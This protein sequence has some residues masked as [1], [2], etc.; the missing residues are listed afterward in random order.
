V[1]EETS[2]DGRQAR[3]LAKIEREIIHYKQEAARLRANRDRFRE[4][5]ESSSDLLWE[6][7]KN[8]VFTYVSPKIRDIL[9]YAPEAVLGGTPFDLMPPKEAQRMSEIFL[10]KKEKCLPIVAIESINLHKDGRR[11]RF[12]T[13]GEPFFN[14]DGNL[15]GYRGV[16]RDITYRKETEEKLRIS[17][18]FQRALLETSPDYTFIIDIE[19]T[20]L[21]VNREHQDLSIDEVM[22][23]NIHRFVPNEYHEP[24]NLALRK[25]LE[26][27]QIQ[28][29]EI[30]TELSD[31][32]RYYLNRLSP[33]IVDEETTSFMII[34]TD[35][36]DQKLAAEAL[37]ESEV[38]YKSLF[39]SASDATFIMDVSE[40]HGARFIE[41]N[42]SALTLFGVSCREEILGRTPE[43]FSP[44][45][46]PDGRDSTEKS[47]ALAMATMEG[48]PQFFEWEHIRSD[49]TLFWVEVNLNRIELKGEFFMQ[50]VVRDITERKLTE[51]ALQAS[52]EKFR[53]IFENAHDAISI[54]EITEDHRA[55]CIDANR[56]ALKLFGLSHRDQILGKT[57]EMFSPPVQPDGQSSHDKV[58]ELVRTVMNGKPQY[59]EWEHED[60]DGMPFWVE[61]NLM[62]VRLKGKD[63]LQVVLRDITERKRIEEEQQK[64]EK[65]KSIGTLAGGIAHDFNNILVGLFGNISIAK[66]KLGDNHPV[67]QYLDRAEQS[68]DRA[69]LLANQLLTFARGGEPV[70][71]DVN[72][73]ELVK[74]ASSFYLSGSKVKP[75]FRQNDELWMAAV[76]KGQIQQVF[77][78]LTINANQAM[79]DGGHLYITLENAEIGMGQIPDL[80][81]GKYIKG[82]VRD[83]GIGIDPKHI[84]RIFDPYFTTKQTG[85]GL[86]LATVFSIIKKHEGHIKVNSI[87]NKG[88]TFTL[89]L[90]ASNIGTLPKEML[91]PFDEISTSGQKAKILVMDDDEMIRET[92]TEMLKEDGFIVETAMDGEQA[93][94]MYKKSMDTGEP[95]DLVIMDLTI[96][97]GIG[98]KEAINDILKIDP[99]ARVIVS[100]GYADDPVLANYAEFGFKGIAAKPYTMK[101]LRSAVS[102]VLKYC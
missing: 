10:Q 32:W 5:V 85:S 79:P 16:T 98:G 64:I 25:T 80:I 97:G 92:A 100:S 66:S 42:D 47:R 73:G 45:N 75:I 57:P 59:F 78:N 4:L 8:G 7:D 99:N 40:E 72:L 52:E 102:R 19:G 84:D 95:F 28:S 70:R 33:I 56:S 35:I 87:L 21:R 36:T 96:P 20:I 86:G 22:G 2:P 68:M 48:S 34:A 58:Q 24:F 81:P 29:L 63:Y 55:I 39:E 71:E 90:P 77:S 61:V 65:L 69:S 3:K 53:N 26:T 89:Y 101:K 18:E 88:T 30:A 74:K 6:V 82:T 11:I 54:V 76:D 62:R 83:E 51:Q 1:C 14:T 17:D 27:D 23:T 93:V 91:H 15:S 67:Y 31:G 9:G 37:R 60:A 44:P 41:C 94:A 38:K 12:E 43:L 46:Q 50:V 49:G 13:S